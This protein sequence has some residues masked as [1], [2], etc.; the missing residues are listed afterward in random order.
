MQLPPLAVKG[1]AMGRA[2]IGFLLRVG[3]FAAGLAVVAGG[4]AGRAQPDTPAK[5][6]AKKPAD[7]SDEA[8]KEE[9]LK[10]NRVASD[11]AQRA[12]LLAFVKDK[13]RATKGIALAVK[14]QKEAKG[15]D[16]P[17]NFSGALTLGKAAHFL[18]QYDAAEYFYEYC[19]EAATRI[20]SGDKML[21]AYE[22][23]IDLYWEAK[24][25][26]DVV[27]VCERFVE[28]RG[29]KELENAKPF[30]LERLVQAKARQGNTD[31]A[32]RIAESLI[33]LTDGGWYFTK[34]KGWVL[35]EAGKYDEA[36]E[37]YQEVLD[38]LDAAKGLGKDLRDRQKDIVRYTLSGLYVD[39][40]DVDAAA[41]QLQTLIKRD[42]DNP[43]YKNDLG[44]IWADH[45]KNLEEAEKLI[46]EALELDRKRQ[47]KAKEEGRVE[48][49]R[50]NAAYLDSMGWV[51]FKQKK[52]KEALPYLKKAAADEDEGNHLE[53]WDHLADVH[54]A[55]GQKD[56]AVAAW[57][58]GL[59]MDDVSKR[60]EERRKQVIAKL[61]A[62]GVEP[63]VKEPEKKALPPK[64]KAPRKID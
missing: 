7:G 11:E 40:K 58:K 63:K 30:V 51:L 57:Q 27:D 32:L 43:T 23:L 9:L 10:F 50:E 47:E 5:P 19:A 36:I 8:L 12:R 61:K 1:D 13:D 35:R 4:P 33:Q 56:E 31:E 18:K 49:V 38:K 52:Y 22:G 20:E 48:E 37:A 17:F 24:R 34:L 41:K 3:A 6:D 42:P 2:G 26:Q 46:R 62:Q 54:M 39:N 21:Q 28:L 25:Y 55:L 59:T 29:P 15:K 60:D 44:F 16:K 14:M 45:D 53:I 64:K